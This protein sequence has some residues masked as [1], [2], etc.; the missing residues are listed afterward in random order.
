M[1]LEAAAQAPAREAALVAYAEEAEAAVAILAEAPREQ[2]LAEIEETF[3][4][5]RGM[6]WSGGI[7]ATDRDRALRA[8]E[9]SL[10]ACRRAVA[11][12]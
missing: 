7:A 2:K 8:V 11:N 1:D 12:P 9:R 10:V 5:E 6:L 3:A 4:S